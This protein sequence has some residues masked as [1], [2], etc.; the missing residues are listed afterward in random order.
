[1]SIY[2]AKRS[3]YDCEMAT[4]AMPPHHVIR[5]DDALWRRIDA[6]NSWR[7]AACSP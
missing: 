3:K 6:Q 2:S 1:M 5:I 7:F 4:G